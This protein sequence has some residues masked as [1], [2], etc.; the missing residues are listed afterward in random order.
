MRKI[1]ILIIILFLFQIRSFS[2]F[3]F[4]KVKWGFSREEV[5]KT[6]EEKPITD[7]EDMLTYLTNLDNYETFLIYAFKENKLVSG[8]YSINV[9]SLNINKYY[10][11]YINFKN[12]LTKKYGKGID[13][14]V[15][16][17]T[18][19]KDDL[20]YIGTALN[21]EHVTFN[22]GWDDNNTQIMLY[23]G[24]LDGK[25]SL[26]IRYDDKKFLKQENVE[27]EKKTLNDL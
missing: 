22:Y 6:E 5:R 23:L 7:E 18:L 16:N 2:D 1:K 25:I 19:Y 15:W 3:D 9:K 26:M 12:L 8:G 21:L 24:K 4:K 17:K 27:S 11:A 10:E 14:T 13:M 20:E